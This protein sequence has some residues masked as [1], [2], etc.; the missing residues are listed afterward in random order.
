MKSS[1]QTEIREAFSRQADG[2]ESAHMNFSS[3]EYLGYV[4]SKIAPEK[5]D[6]VLEIAAGTCACGRAILPMSA[7]SAKRKCFRSIASTE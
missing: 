7:I 3:K 5:T 6:T 4:V 2:F 1:N